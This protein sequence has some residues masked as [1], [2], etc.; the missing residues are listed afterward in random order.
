V[1]LREAYRFSR[2]KQTW[3]LRVGVSFALLCVVASIWFAL[4]IDDPDPSQYAAYGRGSFY[5]YVGVQY[6]MVAVLAPVLTAG[7]VI[8][9]R[10]DETLELL[11]LSRLSPSQILWG[12]VAAR[13]LVL[14][15]VVMGSAPVLAM[16]MGMGGVSQFEIVNAIA[17]TLVT[18]VVFGAIG[19]FTALFSR[20]VLGP[21]LVCM[22]WG[23]G[24]FAVLPLMFA[25][26]CSGNAPGIELD[27]LLA[28]FSPLFA[29][30]Q[31]DANG[32]V[33]ILSYLPTLLTVGIIGAPAFRMAASEGAWVGSREHTALHR[34]ALLNVVGGL[35]VLLGA[36]PAAVAVSEVAL[37]NWTS[38]AAPVLWASA[39]LWTWTGTL[40]HVAMQLLQASQR[41]VAAKLDRPNPGRP[42]WGRGVVWRSV[43]TRSH[44]PSL[45]M[46]LGVLGMWGLLAATL[47]W[48]N[49]RTTDLWTSLSGFSAMGAMLFA[50]VAST[51]SMLDERTRGQLELLQITTLPGWRIALGKVVGVGVRSLPMLVPG[52]IC[53][54][55]LPVPAWERYQSMGWGEFHTHPPF[56]M[57]LVTQSWFARGFATGLWWLTVWSALTV[58]CLVVAVRIHPPRMAWG[59]NIGMVVGL[60]I[61]PLMLGALRWVPGIEALQALLFPLYAESWTCGR[62][63]FG[64]ELPLSIGLYGLAAAVGFAVLTRVLR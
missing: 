8:E 29:I 50:V 26:L 30:L 13:L 9:E 48:G 54:I 19:A 21:V 23:F 38:L 11:A 25:G 32:L 59:V 40:L 51:G 57:L 10:D 60:F 44:G 47:L 61:G 63:G 52:L 34:L 35:V 56:E 31:D 37:P 43:M 42:V 6:A 22:I 2:R 45:L 3:V 64:L 17:M 14:L 41:R 46:Q 36:I 24:A 16:V 4:I 1:L 58:W 27:E 53:L 20:T 5:A 7:G 18:A 49:T 39:A 33:P 55:A 15:T 28:W 12:K 62:L